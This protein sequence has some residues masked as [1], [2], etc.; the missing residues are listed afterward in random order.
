MYN[1]T[2]FNQNANSNVCETNKIEN[3]PLILIAI[4]NNARPL[5]IISHDSWRTR[6]FIVSG[7]KKKTM[8]SEYINILNELTT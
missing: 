3:I 5:P 7:K 1:H 4:S 2:S 8:D 6:V